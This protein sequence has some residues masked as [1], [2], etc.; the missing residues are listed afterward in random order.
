MTD[1]SRRRAAT[2]IASAIAAAFAAPSIVK[3]RSP[4]FIIVPYASGGSIDAMMRAIAKSMADTLDQPVL[5]GKP[6][7][8][9]AQLAKDAAL[10][11]PVIKAQNIVLE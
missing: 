3:A 9:D 11:G 7:W 5:V 6:E 1:V 10:W 2:P 4:I 8:L